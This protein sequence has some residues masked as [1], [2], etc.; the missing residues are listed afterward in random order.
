M[1]ALALVVALVALGLASAGGASAH[2]A[3]YVIVNGECQAIGSDNPGPDV[4]EQNPNRNSQGPASD[5]GH[6]DLFA[7]PVGQADIGNV[8]ILGARHDKIPRQLRPSYAEA[9]EGRHNNFSQRISNV[10]LHLNLLI[11]QQPDP[12]FTVHRHYG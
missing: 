10:N 1:R 2:N 8:K 12:N 7:A 6:L 11:F 5:L 9:S 3:G 4:P